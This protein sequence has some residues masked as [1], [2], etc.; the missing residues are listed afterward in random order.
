VLDSA[1]PIF[2]LLQL[3]WNLFSSN[4]APLGWIGLGMSTPFYVFTIILMWHLEEKVN[5]CVRSVILNQRF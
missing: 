4:P 3:F 1:S 5:G 2:Q